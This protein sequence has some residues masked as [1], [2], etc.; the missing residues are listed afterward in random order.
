MNKAAVTGHIA[1]TNAAEYAVKFGAVSV[2]DALIERYRV[3][4]FGPLNRKSGFSTD[5]VTKRVQQTLFPYEVH[6]VMHEERLNAA[7]TM[8]GFFRDHLLP[9]MRAVDLHDLRK[10]HE[11]R[12]MVQTAEMILRSSTVRKESR[13]TFYR[14]DYPD[15]DDENW[16]KWVLFK[17]DDG[18][19]KTWTEPVPEDSHGDK[20]MP[21][22]ERYPLKYRRE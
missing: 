12:N 18:K 17:E 20:S 22:D 9:R 4:V 15:R 6:M 14:E 8:V 11:A 7:L 16:L 2:D 13:G 5:H 19:M 10:A 21:Y 1:G 3:S